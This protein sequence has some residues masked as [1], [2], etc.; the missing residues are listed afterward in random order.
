MLSKQSDYFSWDNCKFNSAKY[1]KNCARLALWRD[2]GLIETYTVETSCY[3]FVQS[4]E[5]IKQFKPNHFLE[6]G[7]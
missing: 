4:G 2:F 7:S 6:F 3:G 5:K 1:K